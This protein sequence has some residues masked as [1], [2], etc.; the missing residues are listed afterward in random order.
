MNERTFPELDTPA[1]I[2]DLDVLDANIERMAVLARGHGVALRP[3]VKTHKSPWVAR[4]QVARGAVGVTVAKLGEAE[5]MVAGGIDDVLIAFPLVGETKL[6]RL[7]RLLHDAAHVAVSLDDPA[8]AD[9]IGRLGRAL[10]RPVAVYLEFDT[11]LGRVGVPSGSPAI[12][13]AEAVDRIDGVEIVAGMTHGGH[14]GAATSVEALERAARDEAELLV[15]TVEA[16][17]RHGIEVPTVSPGSTLAARYEA[18]TPGVTEIRPGTY[19][20][21][22]ANTV[23]R[24]TADLDDCAAHVLATVVSRPVPDRAVVDAGTKSFGADARVDG[25]RSPGLVVGRDDVE[26]IRASEEHGVLRVD[27]G[28]PLRIGDRVRIV[29]N[30]VC[31]VVDLYDTLIGVRGDRVER[32]IPVTARGRR[33]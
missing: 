12:A 17:R 26:L 19:A 27:P 11:G 3:H 28:S 16:I 10:G 15:E 20:F 14:V 6:S 30:H 22:D 32:E 5:A 2:V 33:T 21:N 9:G 18:D 8:V 23:A 7:E 24:W 4:R 13:L 29:M 25:V 31:P 1:L